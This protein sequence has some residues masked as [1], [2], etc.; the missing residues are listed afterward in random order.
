M[1]S[2]SLRKAL[3]M[4]CLAA[5]RRNP[6]VKAFFD[7]LIEHGKS[8]KSAVIAGMAIL[9]KIIYGVLTHDTRFTPTHARA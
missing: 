6:V 8:G 3:F 1:G 7:H 2:S 5:L 4:P 9:L